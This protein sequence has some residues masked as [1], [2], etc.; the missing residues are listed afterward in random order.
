[1]LMRMP[2]R[3]PVLLFGPAVIQNGIRMPFF[4]HLVSVLAPDGE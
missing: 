4:G 3:F 1:M 2:H